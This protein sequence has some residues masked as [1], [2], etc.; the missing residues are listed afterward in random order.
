MDRTVAT[1]QD[2]NIKTMK[3]ADVVRLPRVFARGFDQHREDA[4]VLPARRPASSRLMV[5]Q[6]VVAGVVLRIING[7]RTSICASVRGHADM[8]FHEETGQEPPYPTCPRRHP[9]PSPAKAPSARQALLERPVQYQDVVASRTAGR[10]V[11]PEPGKVGNG[12]RRRDCRLLWSTRVE[13][14]NPAAPVTRVPIISNLQFD[15]ELWTAATGLTRNRRWLR[16]E[17][18]GGS[19]GRQVAWLFA[20]SPRGCSCRSGATTG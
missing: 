20:R 19:P 2:Q 1:G 11:S 13:P 10:P 5:A 15:G 6:H 16:D 14:M 3:P 8:S 7:Q 4:R 9:Q 17:I 12:G 18:R